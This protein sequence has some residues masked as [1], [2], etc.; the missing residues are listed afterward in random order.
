MGELDE[1]NKGESYLR[2]QLYGILCKDFLLELNYQR[3]PV[4]ILLALY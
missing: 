2:F 4:I 1:S 3:Y